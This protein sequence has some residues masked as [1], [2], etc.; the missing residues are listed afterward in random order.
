MDKDSEQNQT[1]LTMP[2]PSIN[3]KEFEKNMVYLKK[4]NVILSMD[5]LI[6]LKENNDKFPVNSVVITFDDGFENNY[7]VAAPILD[8]LNI[9]ATFYI[10]TSYIN[11]TKMF[12][13]DQIEDCINR[14]KVDSIV[15]KL[16]NKKNI[17][18]LMSRKQKI[19]SLISIKKILKQTNIA[20][21]EK[22]I[23]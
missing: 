3:Y 14:T 18:K 2:E 8:N 19:S 23:K 4:N 20:Q 22:K 17:Y 15:L 10:S 16:N 11:S 13:V 5:E 12:W 7:S 21:K 9:P 6:H 1:S